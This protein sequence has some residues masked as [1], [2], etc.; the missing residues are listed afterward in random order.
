MGRAL[1]ASQVFETP[2]AVRGVSLE[3]EPLLFEEPPVE[4]VSGASGRQVVSARLREGIRFSD[5]SELGPGEASEIL[6]EASTSL[7]LSVGLE[8]V[9]TA[10]VLGVLPGR[11]PELG[12]QHVIYT[13]HHDHL[14]VGKPNDAG[15]DIY[16]GALDNA[17]AALQ[18]L[19]RG[20]IMPYA[21][22]A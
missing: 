10:N 2:C 22:R 4:E 19:T 15:D 3:A 12:Q 8:T 16:N 20:Q 9:E 13:A 11:D 21:A 6:G 14:G 1:V 5:G 7:A 17:A 18:S